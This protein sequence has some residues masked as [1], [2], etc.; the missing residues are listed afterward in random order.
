MKYDHLKAAFHFPEKNENIFISSVYEEEQ[1]QSSPTFI[2][3]VAVPIAA[4]LLMWGLICLLTP[5]MPLIRDSFKK[6]MILPGL[7]FGAV[8]AFEILKRIHLSNIIKSIRNGSFMLAE[9]KYV[10]KRQTKGYY[11]AA[12]FDTYSYYVT[13]SDNDG[14]LFEFRTGKAVFDNAGYEDNLFIIRLVSGRGYWNIMDL[15]SIGANS[16]LGMI[17]NSFGRK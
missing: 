15:Y 3:R 1:K 11:K 5:N 14:N 10:S 8:A 13:V 4:L 2:L 6:I 7:L 9:V 16:P 17:S 12:S